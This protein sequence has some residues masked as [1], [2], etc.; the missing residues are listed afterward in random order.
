MLYFRYD[1][2]LSQNE[3]LK[4]QINTMNYKMKEKQKQVCVLNLFVFFLYVITNAMN[5]KMK[6]K[7]VYM[8]KNDRKNRPKIARFV[9]IE[10]CVDFGGK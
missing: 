9:D 8:L 7:Q 2:L 10:V 4:K 5:Y 1:T 3:C 6:K